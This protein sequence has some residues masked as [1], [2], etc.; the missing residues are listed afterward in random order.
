MANVISPSVKERIRESVK[1]VLKG[2]L[3]AMP[4]LPRDATEL[5]PPSV[6]DPKGL[7]KPFH[8][9]LFPEGLLR[10]WEFERTFSTVLGT[11]F[12]V[13][14]CA[15]GEQRFAESSNGRNFEGPISPPA[16]SAIDD[17]LRD[18]R[19]NGLR[20]SYL[21]LVDQVVGAYV[22]ASGAGEKVKVDL[23]VR[24]AAG[25]ETFFEMKSPKPNKDQC[26]GTTEKLLILHAMRRATPPQVRTY[27]AMP[28][29]PYGD[30]D[31]D[32]NHSF[33]KKYL[34]MEHQVL[35][36]RRF[37]DF[38][39]GQGTYDDVISIYRDVGLEMKAEILERFGLE[40]PK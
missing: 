12:E 18:I 40:R 13:V 19:R 1:A 29:N 28:F 39:G 11:S 24:T 36:G 33:A 3:E 5:R 26:V 14:A 30:S 38:L 6:K 9:L 23:Y 35:V 15:I 31:S 32:Y 17:M 8:Q 16:R 2:K 34:D 7:I 20:V 27:Y 37:W 4:P 22:G 21:D 10:P 25:E